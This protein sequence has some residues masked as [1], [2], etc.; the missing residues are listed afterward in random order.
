ML[1]FKFLKGK[2]S[3]IQ[4]YNYKTIWYI[5]T[6][7]LFVFYQAYDSS[8][9][10]NSSSRNKCIYAWL[11][12]TIKL[13][14]YLQEV[15]W[16]YYTGSQKE[17]SNKFRINKDKKTWFGIHLLTTKLYFGI[18]FNPPSPAPNLPWVVNI[19][20]RK[21]IFL[22]WIPNFLVHNTVLK[23]CQLFSFFYI[24]YKPTFTDCCHLKPG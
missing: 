6:L 10:V 22:Y 9:V 5:N 4:G 1:S 14:H 16:I 12:F 23:Y 2:S 20:K 24:H 18:V 17:F 15:S 21:P 19:F 11:Y 7:K 3:V 13:K 8:F